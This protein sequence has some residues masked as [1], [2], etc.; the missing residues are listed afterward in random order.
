MDLERARVDFSNLQKRIC[1][2]MHA[3]E[4]IYFD[5]E[6]VGPPG[7]ADNRAHSQE[8]L[9]EE[10]FRLKNGPETLELINYLNENRDWL[11]VKE[12]KS[13]DFFLKEAKRKQNIPP[14]EYGRY[15]ALLSEAQASWHAAREANDF[16]ILA[17]KLEEIV[18]N[19]RDFA[20]YNVP[21]KDSYD[22]CL[23]QYEEGLDVGVCD[24]V[25]NAIKREIIPL[26]AAIKE[27]P[28]V[29]DSC[30]KGEFLEE[31]LQ[32]MAV[33]IL[34]LI[35]IDLNKVGLSKAEHPFTISL[36]SHFDERI[37]TRYSTNNLAK[38]L[39]TILNQGGHA[40]YETGQ[41]DNLAYTVL[42]GTASLSL[43]ESQGRFYENV[44]GRSR[45]FIEYIYPEL[46][47]L[48]PIPIGSYSPE[49]IY[50][51]VN[52]IDPGC[53]RINS[54]ELSYNI[55]VLIRYELER[56]M[57]RG[58]LQVKDLPAVWNQK[59]K[60]YLGVDVPDDL[61]GVLQDIHWPFGSFGYFPLYVLGNIFSAQ[62]T[63]KM[64]EE[65]NIYDYVG[66]GDFK[67][68]N[69]W[70]KD[71]IWKYGGLFNTKEIMEKYVGAPISAEPYINYLKD[72][73][74]DIYKL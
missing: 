16:G 5:G 69:F 32:D 25:F 37:A 4:L 59:Y 41:A 6:T 23:E 42:D 3:T 72:K 29:D 53:I 54:D 13:V 7:T 68:I 11:S 12:R 43:T 64:N 15:G 63:Q 27:K 51:A 55:H 30:I 57:I 8:L 35:G 24:L 58:D 31:D 45:S 22:Y 19:I 9:N 17:P 48:F 70:N 56:D 67:L 52:K 60:E 21:D 62:I 26:L 61:N 71:R 47:E 18:Q 14:E 49:D 38:S 10:L 1:A 28:Q 40:L 2:F 39:Y 46:V 36:G 66:E 50:R 33:Y 20:R 44:I 65:F 73:Y 34:D 74:A